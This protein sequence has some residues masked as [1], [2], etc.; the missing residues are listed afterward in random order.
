MS[1]AKWIILFCI[2]V[3][4]TFAIGFLVA[5]IAE[6]RVENLRPT[7]V[8]IN[9]IGEWETDPAVWGRNF[10]REYESW[11]RTGTSKDE[12][13]LPGNPTN[14]PG[15]PETWA[16][17]T[18]RTKWGGSDGHDKLKRYPNLKELYAGFSFAK[19]YNRKRGHAW[20][21]QDVTHTHRIM[22]DKGDIKA[23]VP[24]TCF[25]CKS[26]DVPRLMHEM[27]VQQFYQT[28]FKDLVG[29]V[30]HPISCLDCHDPKTMDL[31]ISRPA[32]VEAMARRGVDVA[33]A[34]HQ[35]MRSYVCSQCHVTYYFQ[36]HKDEDPAKSKTQY[37]TFPWDEA[38]AGK[39][40]TTDDVVEY[41]D[42]KTFVDPK[43]GKRKPFSD[44]TH[45]VSKTPMVKIRHPEYEIWSNG[46][47]AYR[48]VS[49]ADCHMPYKSEGGVKVTDHQAKSPLMG[50]IAQ[51]CQVCHRWSEAEIRSRVESIQ[52]TTMEMQGRAEQALIAAHHAVGDAMK[53]GATD[54]EL[55]DIRHQIR[56]GQIY[57]DMVAAENS[58]GFHA[59]QECAKALSKAIDLGRQAESAAKLLIAGKQAVPP[60]TKP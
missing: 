2:A 17:G 9:P 33:K 31:R 28:P 55:K 58:M 44:W 52:D 13:P 29:K 51:S 14:E 50:N 43:D 48:G 47:H 40:V 12:N 53:A 32:F 6:R 8:M 56:N 46:I 25:T 5:S 21:V 59:P 10:P 60:P 35:E 11:L 42:N 15:K 57:W 7:Q 54:D 22:D 39:P 27:G 19:E 24:G 4:A 34:T 18:G 3:T 45:A 20:A 36:N 30:Q 49:C 23:A 37:L 1:T 26:P 41:F 38:P 16:Y